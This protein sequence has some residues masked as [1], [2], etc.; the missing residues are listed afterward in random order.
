MASISKNQRRGTKSQLF[1]CPCGGEVKMSSKMEKGKVRH[2]ATC[3]KCG[4]EKR[5]PSD[6]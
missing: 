1:Y 5:K 6:F 2:L 4:T 3:E